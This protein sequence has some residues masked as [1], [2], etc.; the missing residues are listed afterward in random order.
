MYFFIFH[1]KSKSVCI[2]IGCVIGMSPLLFID[3]K[4]IENKHDIKK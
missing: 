2:F 1:L 4:E 3:Q